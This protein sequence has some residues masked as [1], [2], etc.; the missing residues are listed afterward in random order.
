MHSVDHPYR[1]NA[2]VVQRGD[3]HRIALVVPRDKGRVIH[4]ND[5]RA[6]WANIREI[7]RIRLIH[8]NNV[9]CKGLNQHLR[10]STSGL[11]SN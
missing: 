10:V 6:G 5:G 11:G 1:P 4:G 9:A 7:G 8:V 2:E 3:A